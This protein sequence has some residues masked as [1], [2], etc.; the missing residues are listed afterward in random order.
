M[1]PPAVA[2]Q[3]AEAF[4]SLPPG[5]KRVSAYVLEHPEDVALLSMRELARRLSATPATMTRFAQR[6]G[7]SG[8]DAFRQQFASTI[9]Q[10]VSDFGDRAG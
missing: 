3:I 5:M 2:D 4:Q 6:L 1:L 9:R 7:Y 10:Q 8:Y